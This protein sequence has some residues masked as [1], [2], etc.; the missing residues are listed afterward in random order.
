LK[1][2]EHSKGMSFDDWVLMEAK[3]SWFDAETAKKIGI[4]DF[5]D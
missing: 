2:V 4:L 5:I 1:L 3:T